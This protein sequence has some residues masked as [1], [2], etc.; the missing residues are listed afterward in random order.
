MKLVDISGTKRRNIYKL[1]LI[2]LKLTVN[3]DMHRGINGG[4]QHRTNVVKDEKDD[5]VT[6]FHC[7]FG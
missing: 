4:Y 1:K 2:L 3:R 5:L 6:D 7:I